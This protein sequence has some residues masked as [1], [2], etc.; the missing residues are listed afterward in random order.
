[1]IFSSLSR[2]SS[3][4]MTLPN[5]PAGHPMHSE[6]AFSPRSG[7]YRPEGHTVHS[8]APIRSMKNPVGHW[9]HLLTAL[10]PLLSVPTLLEN[11]AGQNVQLIW[12]ASKPYIP[13]PQALQND[14]ASDPKLGMS[15]KPLKIS[16][17]GCPR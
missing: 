13:T 17:A 1:M 7:E 3:P 12:P 5:N 10:L 16:T 8:S 14:T 2:P 11:P 4:S 15:S 9:S 6:E